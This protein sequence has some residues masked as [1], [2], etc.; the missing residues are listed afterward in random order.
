MFRQDG[1]GYF[2]EH[3]NAAKTIGYALLDRRSALAA[4]LLM[5]NTSSDEQDSEAFVDGSRGQKPTWVTIER[6][7]C[8]LADRYCSVFLNTRQR[9]ALTRSV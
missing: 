2:L 9:F 1:F 8:R 5:M 6:S 4:G 3:G 7:R